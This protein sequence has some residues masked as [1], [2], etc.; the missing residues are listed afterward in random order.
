VILPLA[1][2]ALGNLRSRLAR[3]ALLAVAFAAAMALLTAYLFL[4][5]ALIDHA[6]R[7]RSTMPDLVVSEMTAGRP[8]TLP[9][10]H[11][12]RL[13]DIPSVGTVTPRVWG[14]LFSSA[15]QGNVIGVGSGGSVPPLPLQSGRDLQA[16]GEMV[17]GANVAEALGLRLG[18]RLALPSPYGPAP[19]LAVVGIVAR[20]HDL[21]AGDVLFTGDG[22]ARA[23][24][25]VGPLEATDF[26]ISVK[27]P[28]ERPVV[29]RTIAD[30]LPGARVVDRDAIGRMYAVGYGWRSGL[31]TVCLLPAFLALLFLAAERTSAVSARE[32]RE[33][34]LQKALG[35]STR[36]VLVVRMVEALLVA[37]V[38][39]ATGIGAAYIW[40]FHASAA[41]LRHA[42]F[43]F[44]VLQPTLRLE[45][46]TPPAALI[47]LSLV[48]IVP[49]AGLAVVSAWRVAT[50][51]PTTTL[52]G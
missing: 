1:A 34:A 39:I 7:V 40:I 38:G 29:A 33:I 12:E 49:Y 24:L 31:A 16:P 3:S 41:G 26:A 48:A 35:Y 21:L 25:G 42:L 10:N 4:R 36:E 8:R 15:L 13:L 30:R 50:Q 44:G 20:E 45:P 32:R 37:E 47:A 2:I 22:D 27:N 14:Y 17:L 23:L 6:D 5:D 28:A 11:R 9:V 51:D 52:R 46:A 18:D 19:A 43:G